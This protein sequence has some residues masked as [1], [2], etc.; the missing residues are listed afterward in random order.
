MARTRPPAFYQLAQLLKNEGYKNF[1]IEI[2]GEVY[3]S[4]QKSGT[5]KG[6][7]SGIAYPS[8]DSQTT[9]NAA[10]VRLSDMAAATSGDYRN[11]YYQNNK[12]Y[13][14]TISPTTGFPVDHNLASV[15]VFDSSCMQADAIATGIMALGEVEGL[16]LANKHNIPIIMFIRNDNNEFIMQTSKSADKLLNKYGTILYDKGVKSE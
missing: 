1:V 15:T 6:W 11:Y 12:R 16:K 7:N 5:N 4:G 3:A 13:S 14:H 8:K 10:V 9:S 2:G